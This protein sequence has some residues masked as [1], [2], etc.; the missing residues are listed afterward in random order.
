MTIE[1]STS[2][3]F[4]LLLTVASGFLDA[5]TYV[6]RGGVF[7]NAQTGNVILMGID[8]SDRH[9][10][11]ALAHVWPILAF[12]V[13]VAFAN[14][15]K[16]ARAERVV[17]YPIRLAV[18]AQVVVLVA[19]GFVPASVPDA[20]VT[21]PIAF[22]AAMQIGLFRTVGT[23]SYIAIATTGNLM[24]LTEAAYAGLVDRDRDA[25]RSVAVYAAIIASFAVGAV[26][27]AVCTR[28]VGGPAAWIPAGLLGAALVLFFVDER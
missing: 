26:V 14:L 27:G 8:L 13:G 10:Q 17:R 2:L 16:S 22:V 20:L 12:L 5:Y 1:T 24:R 21:V 23:L 9:W 11:S 19:V 15:L 28:A 4:A 18:A 3:R 7:A 25:R 6:S